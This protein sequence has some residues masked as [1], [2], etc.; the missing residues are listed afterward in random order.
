MSSLNSLLLRDLPICFYPLSDTQPF[1][2]TPD[3]LTRESV[4]HI[5]QFI[6]L[7]TLSHFLFFASDTM[8]FRLR[9]ALS[10]HNLADESRGELVVRVEIR[11]TG[12]L[13]RDTVP[14]TVTLFFSFSIDRGD[15]SYM[16]TEEILSQTARHPGRGD[17][18][19]TSYLTLYVLQVQRTHD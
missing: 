4:L 1:S 19:S 12:T 18:F 14:D 3:A 15:F 10:G 9:S 13:T 16:Q 11:L 17:V 8:S 6:V 2:N 5:L 7:V